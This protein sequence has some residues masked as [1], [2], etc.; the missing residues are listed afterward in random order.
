MRV[1]SERRAA[2]ITDA[3]IAADK[4]RHLAFQ[5][6]LT[7]AKKYPADIGV[8]S[9][10]LLNVVELQPGEAMFLD[11]GT[12]HAYLEGT[13][14]EVMASSDN[15]LRGGLTPKHIDVPELLPRLNL[16][17]YALM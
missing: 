1:N 13:G 9:P 14:L 12:L 2:V 4:S 10:L 16:N 8:L 5:T 11:A 17:L 7:L 6:L 15:V 3:L